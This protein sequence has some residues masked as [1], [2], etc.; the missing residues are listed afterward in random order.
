M[1]T[2]SNHCMHRIDLR[3]REANFAWGSLEAETA[4][5]G[6]CLPFAIQIVDRDS[7]LHQKNTSVTSVWDHWLRWERQRVY[8]WYVITILRKGRVPS[9]GR[10][11][12]AGTW[13]IHISV[14]P[15]GKI[16]ASL[17]SFGS[18]PFIREE[19][20]E[21]NPSLEVSWVLSDTA[22][23]FFGQGYSPDTY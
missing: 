17:I 20:S 3:L 7:E 16:S 10:A 22:S 12:P 18:V 15:S 9:D 14:P 19:W 1:K 11:G 4:A 23:H 13:W 8:I 5:G 6:G 21:N 2:L